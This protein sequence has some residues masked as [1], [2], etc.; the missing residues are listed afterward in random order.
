MH[1][2][3]RLILVVGLTS[4]LALTGYPVDKLSQGSGLWNS[5]TWSPAGTP[6]AADIVHIEGGNAVDYNTGTSPNFSRVY[7]GDNTGGGSADGTL[8]VS[9]GTLTVNATA[10]GAY[11]VGRSA[12]STGTVNITGGTLRTTSATGGGMQLGFASGATGN[13]NVSSGALTLTASAILGAADGATGHMTV[14]GGTVTTSTGTN[15]AIFYVGGRITSGST[16]GT[17]EQTGGTVNINNDNAYFGVGFAGTSQAVNGT[18]RLTGGNFSGN[19][20]VGR[21]SGTTGTGS[22]TLTIG[23]SANITGRNQAWDISGTGEIVFE[24]GATNAFNAVNLNAATAATALVFSEAGAKITVDGTNLAFS[25]SYAP[26]TFFT[27]ASGK[28]PDAT[29]LS[30]VVFDFVGFDPGFDPELVWTSTSLQLNL[31]LAAIPEPSTYALL[32]AGAALG[33]VIV[34]RRPGARRRPESFI[35]R[36]P[37][38]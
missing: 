30:N 5:I 22:G 17:F 14:S 1:S 2:F 11:I 38:P 21:Q 26:I 10:A 6:V 7:V 29:S 15:N 18:A 13:L 3:A 27:F 37:L 36:G 32:L 19:V 28:G 31:N 24:L 16:V 23:P 9:G 8:A 35:L 12:G 4:L 34:R 25:D 20:R 33:L